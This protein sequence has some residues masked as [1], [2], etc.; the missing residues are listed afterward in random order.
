MDKPVLTEPG[1]KYFLSQT[2]CE[3]RK[4]KERNISIIFNIS[5][6]VVFIVIVG[7]FLTYKYRGKPT[8]SELA[9]KNREKQEYIISKLQQLSDVRSKT[10]QDMIT[11]LPL[12]NTQDEMG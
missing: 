8:P 3:C 10:N 11:G 7:G 1:I 6:I 4:F 5:M 12:W 2:L 9:I